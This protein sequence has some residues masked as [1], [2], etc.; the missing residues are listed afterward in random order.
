MRLSLGVAIVIGVLITAPWASTVA[1]SRVAEDVRA[2]WVTRQALS[3]PASIARMVRTAQKAGFNTLLV[4]VRGRGD[5][6][7]N[8]RVEP[9]AA[10]LASDP[11]FDPLAETLALARPAGLAVHAWLAV[12]LVSSAVELPVS[13]Q[14]VIHRQPDWLMVPRALA[15]EL[16]RMNARSPR[17]LDRLAAWTRSRPSEVEGLYVSPVHPWAATHFAAVASDIVKS[18]DVDGVHLDYVRFPGPDFDYSQAALQQ[19]KSALRPQLTAQARREADARERADPLAYPD[20]YPDRWLSF[21]QSRLTAL[22]M[23]VRTAVKAVRPSLVLSA[24]VIPDMAEAAASRLQDW[25]TWL[26]QGLIDV[27]CPMAYTP[28][29]EAFVRQIRS[30]QAVAANARVWAGIGAYRMSAAAIVSHI[31]AARRERAAGVALFSYDALVSA[32]YTG[33]SLVELGRAAFGPGAP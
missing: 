16:L 33:A 28:E 31:A 10:G 14:H 30:T 25:R 1:V 12:N 24:A 19:F 23:Q 17:Y 29:T 8:S 26:D 21:R 5:A 4:Q 9:R 20:L 2:L 18:Y 27:V 13:R 7:Y 11:G 15:P 32:P 6:Y 22:V 3:S